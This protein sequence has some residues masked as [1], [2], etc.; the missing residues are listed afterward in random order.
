MRARTPAIVVMA[1]A[2]LFS[3]VA[4]P[5]D[6]YPKNPNLDVLHYRFEL[7][8]SDA[9][10]RISGVATVQVRFLADGVADF[11]LDLIGREPGS[12]TGMAVD[13]VEEVLG[14]GSRMLRSISATSPTAC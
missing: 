9:S 7:L 11:E 12:P 10:D 14:D 2:L 13:A 8:L 5:A 4:A 1:L 3:S 6:T